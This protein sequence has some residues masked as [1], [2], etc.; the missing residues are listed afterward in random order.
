M[1]NKQTKTAGDGPESP[2]IPIFFVFV[3]FGREG[4]TGLVSWHLEESEKFRV[5]ARVVKICLIWGA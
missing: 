2:N 4:T 1:K 3:C 5:N